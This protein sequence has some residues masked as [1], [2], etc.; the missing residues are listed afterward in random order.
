MRRRLPQSTNPPLAA[1]QRRRVDLEL[2]RGGEVR[3]RRL[4]PRDI[5]PVRELGLKVAPED[6]TGLDEREVGA[7]QGGGSLEVEHGCEGWCD[8]K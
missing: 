4:E 8:I 6:G 1:R 5:S 2:A 7:V 3:R